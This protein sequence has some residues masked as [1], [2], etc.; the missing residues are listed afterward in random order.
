[1]NEK[2]AI[3]VGAR[4]EL[5]VDD[6]LIERLSPEAS[7]RLHA[8][9]PREVVLETDQPWEGSMSTY[10][11]VFA[12][13]ESYRMYYL[14][15]EI[16]LDR[17][18]LD[19]TQGV[20]EPHPMWACMA[21]SRDGLRWEKPALGVVEY[22]GSTANNIVWCG[23]GDR[24]CGVHGFA[25]FK[26][27]N[28]DADPRFRYKAVGAESRATKGDLYAMG[29]PDGIHWELMQGAPILQQRVHGQ[30][31]KFDSQNLAFWDAAAGEYRMYA[32]AKESHGRDIAT[33]TSM[34]FREW[35]QAQVLE[36]PGAPAEE[37]YTN[38]VMPYPRAPHILVGF[39]S[40]YVQR[41]WSPAIEALPELAHRQLRSAVNER[42]G[43]ALTDGL[44]MSSRDGR[45]FKRWGEAFLRPGPQLEG[46]WSYGDNYQCWGMI[47]TPAAVEGAPPELSFFAREGVWRGD[48]MCIRRYSLRMDGFVSLNAPRAGAE[49][50]TRPMTFEGNRLKLNVATSAAGGVRV[51]LQDVGG[52]P[53]PGFTLDDCY[54]VIGDEH[55]R[56]V[57]WSGG[58][59]VS[60]LA[61]K[62]VKLRFVF[63]DADIYAMRF[64]GR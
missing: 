41:R 5:F 17:S 10:F 47:E 64:V 1:M 36:Y 38:Q 25:P 42:F 50:V 62:P 15:W 31:L 39:P 27:L 35:T 44:F 54:E 22:E 30:T 8:P 6:Y 57:R 61:G 56:A 16:D 29:S 9:T 48:S 21:E 23:V 11:T 33:A 46:N 18:K 2:Q 32:R 63:N 55:D 40:R 52:T 12:D 43:S 37:L 24:L 53:S 28:P 51:E 60:A 19:P 59:D 3:E 34:D 26:D 49:V 14:G 7:L 20:V 13:D 4:R 58:M 45:T